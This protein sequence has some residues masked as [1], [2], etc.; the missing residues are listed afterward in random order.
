[1]R[2]AVAFLLLILLVWLGWKQPFRDQVGSLFPRLAVTPSRTSELAARAAREHQRVNEIASSSSPGTD[3]V[4]RG[5]AGSA[6]SA[7]AGAGPRRDNSW[8]WERSVLDG[9]QRGLDGR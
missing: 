1:M 2:E 6:G 4:Q 9:K 3:S 8:M 7:G 5:S